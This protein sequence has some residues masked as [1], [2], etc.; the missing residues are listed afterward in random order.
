MNCLAKALCDSI[1]CSCTDL[2]N[3]VGATGDEIIFP[4]NPHP[5]NKRGF[6]LNEMTSF[7]LSQGYSLVIEDYDNQLKCHFTNEIINVKQA[8]K[9]QTPK[10]TKVIYAGLD[11][12]GIHHVDV[13]KDKLT[14]VF[15]II[16][17][18]RFC[19]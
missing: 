12:N 9:F 11:A 1:G 14:K 3:Y 16:Y 10:G 19:F 15:F 4:N 17:L 8:P 2:F 18:I 13:N 7:C 5:Y 6:T